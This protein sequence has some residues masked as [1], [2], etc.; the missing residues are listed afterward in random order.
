MQVAYLFS[1]VLQ[2]QIHIQPEVDFITRPSCHSTQGCASEG[3]AQ[4]VSA[5]LLLVI[6]D[7][8]DVVGEACGFLVLSD[9]NDAL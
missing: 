9:G 8:L 5:L 4:N 3:V 6:G 2:I 1:I 7:I